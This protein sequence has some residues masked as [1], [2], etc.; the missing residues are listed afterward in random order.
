[1]KVVTVHIYSASDKLIYEKVY[2]TYTKDGLFCIAFHD[3]DNGYQV[4]KFPLQHIFRIEDYDV[5]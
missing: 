5:E 4:D 1:M 3:A 2:N